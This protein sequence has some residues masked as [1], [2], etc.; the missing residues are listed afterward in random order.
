[1]KHEAKQANNI[2]PHL[3]GA[4]LMVL[5]TTV[6]TVPT[7]AAELLVSSESTGEI[8]HYSGTG[9]FIDA[10]VTAGAGGLST[11][12]ELVFGPDGNLYVSSFG[13]SEVRRYNGTTGAFIDA[14][15]TA[16]A[17]GLSS[18]TGLVFGPDGNLYVSSFGTSEVLRYNG[19][20]GAF[21]NDFVTASS[22]GLSS[23][24]GLVFGS[25][26]NL[27]V[28][29]FST[30]EVLRYSGV[31]GAFIDAFVAAS[32]G[33]GAGGLL[34]PWGLVFGSDGN[35]YVSSFS[36]SEVLRYSGVSGAFID[37]FVAASGGGLIS[38]MGLVFGPDGNLYVSSYNSHQVLRYDGTTG[39]F[40]DA[41]V[42]AGAGG[43]S[44]PWGL[45]FRGGFLSVS[46]PSGRYVT[47]QNFDLILILKVTGPTLSVVGESATFDGAD[48]TA[49]LANCI[50][51]DIVSGG[52][53]VRCPGL[54]GTLLSTAGA[55]TLTVTLNLSDGTS[56]TNT[57]R[58]EG[59]AN[60][61][62]QGL[63]R[64]LFK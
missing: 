2:F 8:L 60:T 59:I 23:P 12:A 6:A 55:H 20:T 14:F 58:W 28:S 45:A 22:G 38:P 31:S 1:M 13:T 37:A 56:A 25:D 33:I 17:G 29:S 30:S 15:V 16:G 54:G 24:L 43:L 44:G 32:G 27:Y 48:V 51:G 53:T 49:K 41:F 10:F 11:P 9:A 64:S 46:P 61:E 5:V 7:R 26:G 52:I 62:P 21:I 39:L 57:V 50:H 3:L 36:T 19:T 63:L 35:L 18:P 47:T 42:T 4:L 40:I 34:D